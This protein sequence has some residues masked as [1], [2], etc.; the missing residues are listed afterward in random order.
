MY[1]TSVLL[2][3]YEPKLMFLN[4]VTTTLNEATVTKAWRVLGLWIKEKAFRCGG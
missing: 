2:K 3:L 1:A 4:R